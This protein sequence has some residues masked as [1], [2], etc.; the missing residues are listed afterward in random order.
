[1]KIN[2]AYSVETRHTANLLGLSLKKAA[3]VI[4]KAG[5]FAKVFSYDFKGLP[6]SK[7]DKI[8]SILYLSEQDLWS[9]VV[10]CD[11]LMTIRGN[12]ESYIKRMLQKER[13]ESLWGLFC[14]ASNKAIGFEKLSQGSLTEATVYQ[15]HVAMRAMHHNARLLFIA[16]NHPSGEMLFSNSDK[17]MT[18]RLYNCLKL[19]DVQLVDHYLVSENQIL[20][21]ENEEG[22]IFYQHHTEE[23]EDE[24]E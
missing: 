13:H 11:D 12:V 22:S 15:R 17:R 10:I 24:M 14:N 1:M 6:Q 21:Y 5:G 9:K 2:E 4:D 16:H 20:S 3:E 8:D 18:Y 23:D 7:L 19:I